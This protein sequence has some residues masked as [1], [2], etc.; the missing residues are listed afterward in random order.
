M[1][2]TVFQ[3]ALTARSPDP[4]ALEAHG[5]PGQDDDLLRG[6]C[7]VVAAVIAVATTVQVFRIGHS[8]AQATWGTP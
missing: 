6:H 4:L 2:G 8:G 7:R 5:A 3:L 1:T